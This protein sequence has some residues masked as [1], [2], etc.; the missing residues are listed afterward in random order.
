MID[1]N[2]DDYMEELSGYFPQIEKR[3]LKRMVNSMSSL[4]T[5][6][7]RD[8]YRGFSLRSKDSLV[9]DGKLNRFR[10]ERIFGKA[11][12]MTMRKVS[13]KYNKKNGTGK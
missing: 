7:M 11:H 5:V 13:K 9:E 6:Y 2:T 1:K 8:W 3:E 4:L 10:V 12:L